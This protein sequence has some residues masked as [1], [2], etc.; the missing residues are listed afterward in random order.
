M[1]IGAGLSGLAAARRLRA[2]GSDVVVLEARD[3]L[4]GRLRTVDAGG[5]AGDVG[6]T[7]VGANDARMVALAG[8]LGLPTWSTHAAGEDV[9]LLEGG[10]ARRGPRHRRLNTR[11]TLAHRRAVRR[12]EELTARVDP[13]RPWDARDAGCL[14]ATTLAAWLHGRVRDRDARGTVGETLTS[15]LATDPE[16]ISLLGALNYLSSGGGLAVL[17]GT[18]N[19][20]Q[21][22]FL[23]GGAQ[24]L[25]ERMAAGLDIELSTPVRR[26]EHGTGG[27]RVLADGL[28]VDAGHVV[29]A[30]P[31]RPAAQ[32]DFAPA[33]PAR[34]TAALLGLRVG[35]AARVVAV[36]DEAFWRAEGLSG[37]AWGPSARF[38]FTHDLSPPDGTPGV[39]SAFLVGG[40]ARLDASARRAAV[41]ADLTACFGER[42]ARPVAVLEVDWTTDPWSAGAYGVTTPPGL[43]TTDRGAM[44]EPHG[45][46]V[47]A[48]AELAVEHQGYMEG[49]LE[50]GDRA[51][52][53]VLSGGGA[54]AALAA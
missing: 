44:R 35:A 24:Q 5:H 50:A 36:Y 6:G 23:A 14:D 42:A 34:R 15:I 26:I 45:R 8:E 54:A 52:D 13:E 30:L 49:A 48:G 38:S 20:A 2:A 27:V 9:V 3:R 41:L 16:G 29:V 51:A 18:E 7:W 12:I 28:A 22:R 17:A 39:M 47:W 4:G 40:R 1:V 43:L 25:A 33:L 46:I 21:D 11:S 10:K 31:P 19:G 32:L 53:V 37:A